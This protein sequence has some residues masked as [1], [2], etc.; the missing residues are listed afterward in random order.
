M[1]ESSFTPV[2]VGRLSVH[3][4]PSGATP[5]E[6]LSWESYGPAP[7][8]DQPSVVCIA[9]PGTISRFGPSVPMVPSMDVAPDPIRTAWLIRWDQHRTYVPTRATFDGS[10]WESGGKSMRLVPVDTDPMDGLSSVTPDGMGTVGTGFEPWDDDATRAP[11]PEH[12]NRGETVRWCDRCGWADGFP[13][14]GLTPRDQRRQDAC[15]HVVRSMVHEHKAAQTGRTVFAVPTGATSDPADRPSR[16]ETVRTHGPVPVGTGHKV[17]AYTRRIMDGPRWALVR[18]ADGRDRGRMVRRF[19][20]PMDGPVPFGTAQ[21]P[22]MA[23]TSASRSLIG[24]GAWPVRTGESVRHA[25]PDRGAIR[26]GLETVSVSPMG[27]VPVP[28]GVL[29]V[30]VSWST[31]RLTKSG[32]VNRSARKSRKVRAV[33]E[34]VDA[35]IRSG[36]VPAPTSARAMR[37]RVA[38]AM[39][40]ERDRTDARLSF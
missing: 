34:S 22:D 5:D 40:A 28:T 19:T 3:P 1:S 39:R 9:D 7:T 23:A 10:R 12:K 21:H 16:W 33:R 26:W 11:E 8:P 18:G 27:T 17:T 14:D 25:T 31:E 37:R 30:S 32:A 4:N 24:T 13:T 29:S 20:V 38:D 35:A 15:D 2:P 6:V 36:S